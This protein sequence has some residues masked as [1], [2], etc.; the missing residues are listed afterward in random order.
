MKIA[1]LALALL[2][3]CASFD[4]TLIADNGK[5]YHCR[6]EGYGI[7]GSLVASGRHEDCVKAAQ[8]KGYK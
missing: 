2:A 7:I 1:I 6:Q 3:G 5:E 8:E 4:K